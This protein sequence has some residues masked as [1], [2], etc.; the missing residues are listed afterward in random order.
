MDNEYIPK[1]Y[2]IYNK[3]ANA[4]HAKE[5]LHYLM[6]TPPSKVDTVGAVAELAS[7]IRDIYQALAVAE[8]PPAVI[9]EGRDTR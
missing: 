1:V 6:S 5:L 4:E 2:T 7:A 9:H 8:D 3:K